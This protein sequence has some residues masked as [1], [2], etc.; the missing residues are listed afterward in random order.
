M[1]YPSDPKWR[2]NAGK[3][4]DGT[5]DGTVKPSLDPAVWANAVTDE[6]LAVIETAGL[7]PTEGENDQMAEA[8]VAL[9]AAAIGGIAM[10]NLTGY[11]RLDTTQLWTRLQTADANALAHNTGWDGALYQHL[12]VEV[13]GSLFTVANPTAQ[14]NKA[15]YALYVTYTTSHSLAFGSAF[16]GVSS[17]TPSNTAGKT[18]VFF[19][20]SNGTHLQCTGYRL[21]IGG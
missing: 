19:F 13:N 17:V 11:A 5:P 20:R 7:V 2:L 16:K 14:T 9:I 12:A 6:I 10:P 3:F 1:D 18:D 15:F 8:I 21:D 4:T